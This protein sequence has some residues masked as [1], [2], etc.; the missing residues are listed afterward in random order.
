M[1]AQSGHHTQFKRRTPGLG[2]TARFLPHWLV[3][4]LP[5]I[6]QSLCHGPP[7]VAILAAFTW[8]FYP[9]MI[10]RTLELRQTDLCQSLEG[11]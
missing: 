11:S 8:S 1:G 7:I 10:V 3:L 2:V 6:R 5:L 4:I 9:I